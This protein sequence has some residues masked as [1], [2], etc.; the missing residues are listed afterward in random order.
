LKPGET[1]EFECEV[2]GRPAPGV[3]W[4][5]EGERR[6]TLMSGQDLNGRIEVSPAGTLRIKEVNELDVGNYVCAAVNSVGSAL[7]KTML[8]L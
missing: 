5:K 1:A 8:T 2:T 6:F 7:K 3:V 4:S